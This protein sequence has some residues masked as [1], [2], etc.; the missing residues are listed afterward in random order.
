MGKTRSCFVTDADV[1]L[2][3]AMGEEAERRRDTIS[4]IL[5]AL[6]KAA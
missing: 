4:D 2:P 5:Y 6:E 1:V 3:G